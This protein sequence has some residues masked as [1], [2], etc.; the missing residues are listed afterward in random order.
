MVDANKDFFF[1][2]KFTPYYHILNT[3]EKGKLNRNGAQ[4]I[5]SVVIVSIN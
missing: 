4:K 5:Y 1:L 3:S 2:I